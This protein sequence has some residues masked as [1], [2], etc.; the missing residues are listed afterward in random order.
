MKTSR[1]FILITFLAMASV[2]PFVIG[3]ESDSVTPNDEAPAPTSED[4][5][6]VAGYMGYYFNQA[7]GVFQD[8]L[9]KS[10]DKGIETFSS[11]G[12]SGSYT[13]DFR[14]GGAE[15]S[16]TT[17]QS[18]DYCRAYTATGQ[19]VEVR[20]DPGDENPLAVCTF[21]VAA[22]PYDG[23]PDDEEGT[24]NGAGTLVAGLNTSTFV[25]NDV[26]LSMAAYP[27]SGAFTYVTGAHSVAVTFN[28]TR[29]AALTVGE[30]AYTVDLD[31]GE[32]TLNEG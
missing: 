7:Y 18:A 26:V 31:T 6:Y 14:T 15:G 22:Y 16:S 1:V 11:G 13:L 24:C 10:G 29:Y 4:A 8:A 5:A 27:P 25:I 23:T 20:S 2:L 32:V 12:V 9:A 3:C 30:D 19:Q 21:D 17:S 28:G